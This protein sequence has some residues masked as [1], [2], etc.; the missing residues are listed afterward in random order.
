M[1]QGVAF[2]GLVG[3]RTQ[4]QKRRVFLNA[5]DLNASPGPEG[6]EASKN[7]RN[8]RNA[9][10]NASVLPRRSLNRNLS[11]GFLLGNLLPKTR[12]SERCVLGRKRGPNANASVLGTLRFRTLI[13][14]GA[15]FEG[16]KAHSAARK[17]LGVLSHHLKREMK[18][19]HLVDF[20]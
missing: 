10:L 13:H 17:K 6:R 16:E 12:V 7:A 20:S 18:S 19:P 14:G 9:F 8:D 15:S 2:T 3:F 1:L 4:T 11:W 5:K